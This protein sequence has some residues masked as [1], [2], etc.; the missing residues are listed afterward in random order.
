MEKERLRDR[1]NRVQLDLDDQDYE[2]LNR[3]SKAEKLTKTEVLR[4]ALRTY[5]PTVFA[6]EALDTAANG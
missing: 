2:L 5:R 6:P 4:R 1:R 3:F